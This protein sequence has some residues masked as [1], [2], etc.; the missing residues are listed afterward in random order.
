MGKRN[1]ELLP[2]QRGKNAHFFCPQRRNENADALNDSIVPASS[3]CSS[4]S[5]GFEPAPTIPGR[6][7]GIELTCLLNGIL[8]SPKKMLRQG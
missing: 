5:S 7:D 6:L 3:Y 8:E 1:H 2:G 4:I